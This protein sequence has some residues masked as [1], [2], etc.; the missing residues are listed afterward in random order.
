[1]PVVVWPSSLEPPRM[2]LNGAGS[3]ASLPSNSYLLP[4]N[5]YSINLLNILSGKTS[6]AHIHIFIMFLYKSCHTI[7]KQCLFSLP[8]MRTLSVAVANSCYVVAF[9]HWK[10]EHILMIKG[11][12]ASQFISIKQVFQWETSWIKCYTK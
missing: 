5:I 1:M 10:D 9:H 6:F 12:L 11:S 8:T 3:P 7:A 2:V 4:Q